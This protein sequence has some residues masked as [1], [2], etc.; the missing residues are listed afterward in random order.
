[1]VWLGAVSAAV[2]FMVYVYVVVLIPI[3]MSFGKDKVS[4]QAFSVKVTRADKI[5]EKTGVRIVKKSPIVAIISFAVI[6]A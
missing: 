5:F 3:F 4:Q 6:V 1:M 2:V